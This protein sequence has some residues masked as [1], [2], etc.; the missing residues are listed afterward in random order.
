MMD[1]VTAQLTIRC[2]AGPMFGAMRFRIIL[3]GNQIAFASTCEPIKI[4]IEAGPHTLKTQ[5]VWGTGDK[6][7]FEAHPGDHIEFECTDSI[8]HEWKS[9][10]RFFWWFSFLS[11]TWTSKP[12]LKRIDEERRSLIN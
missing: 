5:N 8:W 2:G 12:T 6:A 1:Q 3:D 4:L 9:R 11:Y 10:K 7:I